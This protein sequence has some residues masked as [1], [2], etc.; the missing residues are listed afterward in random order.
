MP[1]ESHSKFALHYANWGGFFSDPE[2]APHEFSLLP[3]W[4]QAEI[5]YSKAERA[6]GRTPVLA[7]MIAA[8]NAAREPEPDKYYVY[9]DISHYDAKSLRGTL[10]RGASLLDSR[11][12][13]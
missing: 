3:A 6:A 11:I 5:L 9:W 2:L 10:M 4:R 7:D 8:G 12:V 1:T 13:L